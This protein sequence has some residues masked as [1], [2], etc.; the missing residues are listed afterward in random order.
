MRQEIGLVYSIQVNSAL[1][2]STLGP[3]RTCHGGSGWRHD[4]ATV[5]DQSG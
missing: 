5:L 2:N 1:V 3:L 4:D